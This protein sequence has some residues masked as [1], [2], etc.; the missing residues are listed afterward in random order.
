MSKRLENK[1]IRSIAESKRTE[2]D[3]LRGHFLFSASL[4]Y[5]I[6]EIKKYGKKVAISNDSFFGVL[7]IAF[8]A[9]FSSTH[10][11][12]NYYQKIVGKIQISA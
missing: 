12:Y 5:V 3:F 1:I 6:A 8:E 11:H 10:S 4:K 7:L 9:V 2:V